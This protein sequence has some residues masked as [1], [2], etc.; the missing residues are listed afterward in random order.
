MDIHPITGNFGAEIGGLDLGQ[1]PGPDLVA[2]ID[3]AFSKYKVLVFRDQGHIRPQNLLGLAKHFG[4]PD[5]ELRQD[6]S[7]ALLSFLF[8]QAHIPEHQL[9]ATWKPGTIVAWDNQRTQHYI[10]QDMPYQRIM[11]RVMV[12]REPSRQ[13]AAAA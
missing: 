9:R 2:E 3:S 4:K 7:D 6:E 12:H 5:T 10:V 8:E 13:T 1:Q 11:H